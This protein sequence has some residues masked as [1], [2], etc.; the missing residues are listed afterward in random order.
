MTSALRGLYRR[1]LPYSLRHAVFARRRRLGL[2]LHRARSHVLGA[3]TLR[4]TRRPEIIVSLTSFPARIDTAWM[5]IESIFA[6]SVLPDRIVLVLARSE[7]GDAALPA[8]LAAQ[9][10]RGLEILWIDDSL[11]SY[12][13]LL[14]TRA[15]CPDAH[16]VTIDDDQIYAPD[17]LVSLISGRDRH[18]GAVVA[19]RALEIPRGP[20]G[21]L[22][23]YMDWPEATPQTPA[24]A[25]FPLGASGVLYPPGALDP[26]LLL[27]GPRARSLSPTGDDIWF[28]A[29]ARKSSAPTAV[30]GWPISLA[31]AEL[32]ATP[33]LWEINQRPDGN[34]PQIAQVMAALE[35]RPDH[36]SV[37]P[38][39]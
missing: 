34:D 29:V 38:A 5:A 35:I 25:L 36:V 37:P 2:A 16:I 6:Q 11:R 15:A 20:D 28:W 39:G 22:L 13:K 33:S 3:P 17:A 30:L 12:N 14:P 9:R 18:P 24:H 19:T 23:P 21:R 1:V 7:F 10:D 4:P 27:D 8:T 31:V 26:G 32:S